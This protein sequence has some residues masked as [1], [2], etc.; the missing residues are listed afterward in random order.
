M[1]LNT[2]AYYEKRFPST[3]A[4]TE[5]LD[6]FPG[7][8]RATRKKIDSLVKLNETKNFERYLKT[9]FEPQVC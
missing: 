5:I 6:H 1:V 8:Y 4:Q 7:I 9:Y 2:I 3:A